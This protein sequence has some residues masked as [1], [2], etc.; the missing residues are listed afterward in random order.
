MK[1]TLNKVKLIPNM[2]NKSLEYLLRVLGKEKADDEPFE[3]V[4]ILDLPHNYPYCHQ[5]EHAVEC[6]QAV[7]GQEKS[8][9][10]F[11][12]W[13][14][15]QV[16]HF[17]TDQCAKYPC[18]IEVAET[19]AH[20]IEVAERFANG[21]ATKEEL[22]VAWHKAMRFSSKAVSSG[23]Y[24]EGRDLW[25]KSGKKK[26][27]KLDREHENIRKAIEAATSTAEG[28]SSYS[29]VIQVVRSTCYIE[30]QMVSQLQKLRELWEIET[31][32]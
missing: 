2:Y 15:R 19:M 6:W 4:T 22:S 28:E 10:L 32:H 5:I 30:G 29:S 26:R 9:R 1:I 24:I 8:M 17:I 23:G 20:S 18:Y 27:A 3:L 21:N 7:D 11:A 25:V 16:Q 14:A 31:Y 12:V 13:C